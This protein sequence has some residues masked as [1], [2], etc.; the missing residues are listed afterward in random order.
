MQP[1]YVTNACTFFV[2]DEYYVFGLLIIVMIVLLMQTLL[3]C[4][5]LYRY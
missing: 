5:W 3:G 2:D 4:L 1:L